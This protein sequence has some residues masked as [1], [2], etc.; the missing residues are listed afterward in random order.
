MN[1]TEIDRNFSV[2]TKL[3]ERNIVWR[4]AGDRAFV[5]YGLAKTDEAYLRMPRKTAQAVNDGVGGLCDNTSGVRIR[6]CTDSPYIAIQVGYRD[7]CRLAH[8]PLSGT[9]GFDLYR[10]VGGQQF[11]VGAYIPPVDAQDTYEGIVYTGNTAG[12]P[13]NYVLN[14]PP[15]SAV[16]KLYIGLK[17]GS[18]TEAPDGYY[19]RLPVV[20][21]GSSITQGACA[22]RPGS[23]YQNF[24][25]R[26]LNMDYI[27]LG[28]SGSARGEKSIADYIA[29]LE[30]SVFVSD[31]DHNAPSAAYLADTHYALYETIRGRCPDLPYIMI[32]HPDRYIDDALMRRKT[33]M[34]SY[35]RAVNAGDRHVYFI[36]G[37]SLFAGL[38][39]DACTVD[40]CHPN[41]LGMYRMAQG[42]LPL[43]KNLL[44]P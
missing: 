30:M 34:E 37:D 32:S 39:Y 40:I 12:K 23:I 35:V 17:E 20:F 15:Y 43:L 16:N 18:R 22:S 28:F 7:L 33:V 6:L 8:M 4:D 42:M 41:D 25:S 21:Y 38:E 11:Y 14:L 1:I 36:D 10:E 5:R 31:Y 27:S 24:L 9:G 26:A 13:V 44:Y 3:A 2:A 29:G 19:N